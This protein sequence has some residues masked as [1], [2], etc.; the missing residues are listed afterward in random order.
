MNPTL[1][2]YLVAVHAGV[3]EINVIWTDIPHPLSPMGAHGI[4]ELSI[5]GTG[6][7]GSAKRP[8]RSPRA[9]LAGQVHP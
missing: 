6:V 4:G 9:G 8:W 1:A 5:S 2:E 3:P 7:L